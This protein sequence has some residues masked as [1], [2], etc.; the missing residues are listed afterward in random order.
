MQC[1]ACQNEARKFGRD[2]AGNQRYQCQACR[3]TFSDRPAR[4]LKEMRLPLDKAILCL[5]LLTEG[6]SIRATVRISGVA[7]DTVI[8]L[9]VTVG[10]KCEALLR[11]SLQAVPAKDVQSD[12]IWSFVGMKEKTKTRKQLESP[13]I[14]D[15]Y[16]FVAIERTTKLILA[17]YLGKRD[18]GSTRAFL[19]D[20]E[21]S[22]RGRIQL[23]TDGFKCY[24]GAVQLAFAERP[25]DHGTIIKEY[26]TKKDDHRYSPGEEIGTIKGACCGNPDP[27]A[28]CTSHVERHNLTMR[29]QNRRLTRL[30]NGFSKKWAN[31]E[32]ALGLYLAVYN[33]VR[34]HGTLTK[35]AD[36]V[37]TTPAMQA[38]LTDHAWTLLELLQAAAAS[39]R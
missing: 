15:A 37:K 14:G 18:Q 2:R 36:G 1:P 33:Y 28:I 25:V 30:T 17:W 23:S 34:P 8:A 12:E 9:L 6:N 32:A 4:P 16:C 21:R 11:K 22:T 7:K 24:P 35:N 10:E 31:H 29:M 20:V 38:A 26:A 5:Q 3:K 13:D 27:D 19:V 39:T